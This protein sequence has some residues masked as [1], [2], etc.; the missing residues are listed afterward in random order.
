MDEV[1]DAKLLGTAENVVEKNSEDT[2]ISN[3]KPVPI[4]YL[5]FIMIGTKQP[6]AWSIIQI[7]QY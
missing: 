5:I 2:P 7:Y 6:A 3:E 4:F 1:S